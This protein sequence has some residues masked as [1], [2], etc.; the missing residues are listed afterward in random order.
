MPNFSV[1]VI[2]D[3]GDILLSLK[4]LLE[5]E[6]YKVLL[7]STG[8]EGMSKAEGS[9]V[10]AVMLDLVL[11]DVDGLDVLS[12]MKSSKADLPVIIISGKG[13]IDLAVRATKLGAYDFIEKPLDPDRVL[14]S[15]QHAL[16][17]RR[18]ELENLKLR[19][20]LG[21]RYRIVGDSAA[22]REVL[23]LVDKVAP[24]EARVL[25]RGESGVGKELVA[26]AIHSLSP[27]AE[28]PFVQLNCAAI[29]VD[30][31]ESE[32]FGHEKGAFTGAVSARKGRFELAD[33][34]TLFLDE[35]GD[36]PL[37]AQAKVL[38]AIEEGEFERV[39]GMNTVKV[40]VRII[41]A[42]NKDIEAE[43]RMGKFREDLYYRLNVVSISVP[44]LRERREDVPALAQ[45]FCREFCRAN[46]KREKV[47]SGEALRVL[48]SYDWPGNVRELKNTI[49]RLVILGEGDT[50][51]A[52]DVM[53]AL[54]RSPSPQIRS[55]GRSLREMVEDY[56]R[57][58]VVMELE[59]NGWNISRTAEKLGI[60]R[61]NLQKKI[62]A[63]RLKGS[64]PL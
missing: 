27:R 13:T 53:L 47:I 1:L 51:S 38:R 30:L 6:G 63:W 35:I 34:G 42:T 12:K 55:S 9:D 31:V 29:P 17:W 64:L 23:R 11:P 60:D 41:A 20:Q 4:G 3:D 18:L 21:E 48:K 25:I 59:A 58:L 54:L 19:E 32:L 40:D 10:D 5:D 7:A 8:G 36:M 2:D 56:E 44:P 33:G 26:R 22:M 49:E 45:H 28:G 62:K 46:G 14:L 37:G 61:S 16:Q 43:I 52:D 15:L 57:R 39:G 50:I 24:T